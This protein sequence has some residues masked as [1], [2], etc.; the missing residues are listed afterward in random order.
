[1]VSNFLPTCLVCVVF[2]ILIP[3]IIYVL[4]Y[5]PYKAGNPDDSLMTIVIENQFSM[6]D[7]H[8]NLNATHDFSSSWWQWPIMVRP[9]W[10]YVAP[11][12]GE[13]L[14]ATIVSFGNPAIWWVGIAAVVGSAVIAW[15]KKD[16]RMTVVFV[17]YALQYFPWILVTRC[18]FIYHYFTSVPFMILMIVYCIDYFM[19]KKRFSKPMLFVYLGLV[20]VLFVLFYPA[21]SGMP[22]SENYIKALRW[23]PSWYF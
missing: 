18:A 4:S 16:K 5:I 22:V 20:F 11:E 12:A 7:Y 2:F 17:A 19:E 21:L 10:Y 6:F 1:M 15:K 13:G 23:F 9:I 8:S 3:G 14:R